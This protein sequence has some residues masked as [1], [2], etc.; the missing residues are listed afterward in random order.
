MESC[1][2]K[3][4]RITPGQYTK[5][6]LIKLIDNEI[7]EYNLIYKTE[8]DVDALWK[9][10]ITKGIDKQFFD[11]IGTSIVSDKKYP[12]YIDDVVSFLGYSRSRDAVRMLEKNYRRNV[13]YIEVPASKLSN[14]KDIL[15]PASKEQTEN[16]FAAQGGAAIKGIK[17]SHNK[18]HIFLTKFCFYAFSLES[19]T[20]TAKEIRM[21][22][23]DVYN[24]FHDLLIYCRSN[25]ILK[26]STKD[27]EQTEA[28]NLVK[29]KSEDDMKKMKQKYDH[30]LK[31]IK[32]TN[33]ELNRQTE[34]LE[35]NNTVL[36]HTVSSLRKD[37]KEKTKQL[38]TIKSVSE[39]ILTILDNVVDSL[40]DPEV[41]K[42]I[43][44][45][46]DGVNVLNEL[47]RARSSLKKIQT[48]AKTK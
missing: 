30:D 32:E 46:K 31:T 35:E 40:D 9:K 24:S 7:C 47:K 48:S 34:E 21:Q 2:Y 11:F 26:D 6:Q 38:E 15:L 18:R 33:E 5:K 3:F 13:D 42:F 23:I 28:L 25:L 8:I 29:K 4:V 22:V 12:I 39:N 45:K 1:G 17:G 41:V 14:N 19:Q 27:E 44:K 20:E 43:K 37:R 16:I 10:L 36:M